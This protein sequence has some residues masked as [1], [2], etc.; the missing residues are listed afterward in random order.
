MRHITIMILFCLFS[1]SVKGQE[2]EKI[3]PNVE[4][5]IVVFKTHFDIGYTS[6]FKEVVDYYRTTMMDKTFDL[7]ED[8]KSLPLEQQF[9]WTIPGWVM[10]KI[11]ED[12]EG[13]TPERSK[14]LKDAFE[15][16]TIIAHALPFTMESDACEPEAL[17]RGLGFSSKLARKY[18]LPLSRSGKQTDVPS[19]AG[20]CATVMANAGIKFVH[21]GCNWPSDYVKTP[22]LFWWEGPDGSR[23]LTYY[24]SLY[25]SSRYRWGGPEEPMAGT[26]LVPPSE[27]PYRVWPAIMVTGDNEGAPSSEEVK[28]LL[29]DVKGKMPHVKIRMGTMDDFY[30]ALMKEEPDLPVVKQDMP[31]S[32]VHGIMCDPKGTSMSR[33]VHPMMASAEALNTQLKYWGAGNKPITEKV[34]KAYEEILLFGEHTWGGHR[35]EEVYGDDFKHLSSEKYKDLESSWEDK[36]DHIRDA[37]EIAHQISKDNMELLANS[38]KCS[39]NL[40]IVYNPLPWERSGIVETDGKKIFVKDVPATGYRIVSLKEPKPKTTTGNYVQSIENEYFIIEFDSQKG[41]ISSIIDKKTGREWTDNIYGQKFGQYMNER[42]SYDQTEKYVKDYQNVRTDWLHPGLHKPGLANYRE[43]AYRSAL[44]KNGKLKITDNGFEQTA[45]LDMPAD[46]ANHMP[47]STL[48]VT[49]YKSQPYIDMEVV[50]K[51]KAKD[52]WPESDWLCL[53]FKIDKPEFT[54]H[55]PLGIMNP[56]TDII[57]GANRHTYTVGTGVTI[58]GSDGAGVAVCP[59]DH[60]L[61]SL[62]EPGCW[63][64]TYDYIPEKPI[65]YVNLYNNQWNTN[66]RYW[67]PGT[68]NSRIRI[69]FVDKDTNEK[70]FLAINGL[71]A[72]NPLQAVKV[73]KNS[74]QKLPSKQTGIKMSRKGIIVTAFGEDPDGNPGTLFRVWEQ[75]GSS[76]KLIVDL[77]KG[78]N[79]SKAVP[80]NLRGEENGPS[81]NLKSRKLEFEL[82]AYAP[83]SYILK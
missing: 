66:F 22:G 28:N 35:S 19:H 82:E 59:V 32:W 25:G 76:G 13:Q 30:D 68:W 31:D 69:W 45:E 14:Q 17:V 2:T 33:E 37:Y 75:A 50:I 83:A 20:M 77:P 80:V 11:L 15:S 54:V 16:G 7:M 48:R 29:A 46:P 36:A 61:I 5:I 44:A 52:N 73:S 74:S 56:E 34:A 60:P 21:I 24:N 40:V 64:H 49:L 71:E 3:N 4:E 72:R 42:F 58:I 18:G 1:F 38:V 63:K 12:W 47:A 26:K 79:V 78:M 70:E 41:S 8:S 55:R 67:Y 53:P 10:H 9:Q 62:G 57:P 51:D 23:V 39:P 81:I 43:V 6:S 65:V 27:W